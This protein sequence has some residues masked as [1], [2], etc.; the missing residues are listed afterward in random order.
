[1]TSIDR[2]KNIGKQIDFKVSIWIG[3]GLG[4]CAHHYKNLA[5]FRVLQHL[6]QIFPNLYVILQIVGNGANFTRQLFEL[7][8]CIDEIVTASENGFMFDSVYSFM[9]DDCNL[10]KYEYGRFRPETNPDVTFRRAVNRVYALIRFP[11]Q[12][13]ITMDDFFQQ[14]QLD[15]NDFKHD[16]AEIHL[17]SEEKEFGD[18]F[19]AV[20]GDKPLVGIHWFSKDEGR[21]CLSASKWCKIIDKLLEIN[22]RIVV[23]GAPHEKDLNNLNSIY[24]KRTAELFGLWD[25][26]KDKKEVYGLFDEPIR[27]KIAVLKQCDYMLCIDGGMMH[28]AWL[29]AVPT[30]AVV[31]KPKQGRGYLDNVNGYHWAAAAGEPFAGRLI[32]DCGMSDDLSADKIISEMKKLDGTKDKRKSLIWRDQNAVE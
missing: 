23:F 29:H 2:W 25:K 28:L 17:S 6:K 10:N 26:I 12:H 31:E 32:S 3:G 19:K 8:P 22:Y 5:Y 18:T 9:Q 14:L 1:M 24:H 7:D 4:D 27:K 21:T 20:N 15:I 30:L 13:T 16:L 11:R